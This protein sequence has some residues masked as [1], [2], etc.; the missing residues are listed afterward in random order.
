MSLQSQ[1]TNFANGVTN[2]DPWQAMAEAGTPDPSF[3]QL[4]HEEFNR[5]TAAD[6]TITPLSTG[7]TGLVAE[8]GGVLNLVTAAAVSDSVYVQVP[9]ASYQL[10]A[11]AHHFFKARIRL[12]TVANNDCYAGLIA[13]GTVP[14][15]TPVNGIF[16]F[17]AAA[18]TTWVL[19]TV[20]AGVVTDLAL[21]A[22]AVMANA[23][24][25][26]L[27]FHVGTNG[28]VETFFNPTTG[29]FTQVIPGGLRGRATLSAP[30]LPTVVLSPSFGIRN[31]AVA[32]ARTMSIDYLTVSSEI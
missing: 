24:W 3:S 25:L 28:E 22:S 5:Y 12:A 6:W 23:T 26:E 29:P 15:V 17:K 14:L 18:S 30:A 2:C 8:A 13:T 19:R 7:T 11:G 9:V 16:F 31:E 27:S 4:F 20:V 21:P 10:V 1:T 32:T